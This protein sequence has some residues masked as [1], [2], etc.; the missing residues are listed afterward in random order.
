MAKHETAIVIA[1]MHAIPLTVIPHVTMGARAF[2]HPVMIPK[3][4]ELILPDIREAVPVDVSL[5]VLT[6][7]AEATGDGPVSQNGG[8]VDSRLTEERMIPYLPFVISQ[9]T[10]AAIVQPDPAFF[11]NGDNEVHQLMKLTVI[12]LQFSLSACS[13]HRRDRE[14]APLSDPQSDQVLLEFLQP[15]EI[16]LVDTGN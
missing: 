4:L 3:C 12:Q 15:S 10:L 16:P 7:D 14:N 1:Q 2:M 8:H 11:A 6:P 9:E 13:P 5:L